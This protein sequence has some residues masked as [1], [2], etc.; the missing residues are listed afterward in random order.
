MRKI[1][2]KRLESTTTDYSDR[3]QISLKKECNVVLEML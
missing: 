3:N 2:T 1:I